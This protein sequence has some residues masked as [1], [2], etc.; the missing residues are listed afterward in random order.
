MIS[1]KNLDLNKRIK[2]EEKA[3]KN[4]IHFWIRDGQLLTHVNVNSV[5]P[6]YF[7]N[8]TINEYIEEINGNKC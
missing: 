2:I 7:T 3:Y 1:I 6:L 8:N 5:N 4:I